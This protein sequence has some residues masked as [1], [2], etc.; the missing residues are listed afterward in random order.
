MAIII[1]HHDHYNYKLYHIRLVLILSI[2]FW[3]KKMKGKNDGIIFAV[4]IINNHENI[5]MIGRIY[6]AYN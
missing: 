4:A 3:L 2:L 6:N 1:N 5:F